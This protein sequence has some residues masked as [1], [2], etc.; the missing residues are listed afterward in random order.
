[1]IILGL[2][3]NV[4]CYELSG[5]AFVKHLVIGLSLAFLMNL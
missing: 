2:F 4:K 3:R 5:T 1:M